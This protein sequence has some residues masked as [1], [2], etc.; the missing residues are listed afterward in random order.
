[1]ARLFSSWFA[2]VMAL[3]VGWMP[4][5]TA[6]VLP[7]GGLEVGDFEVTPVLPAKN[8]SKEKMDEVRAPATEP[9]AAVIIDCD[10]T[11]RPD[12]VV[13]KRLILE[14]E[15]SSGVTIDCDGATIDV[16]AGAVESDYII[17]IRSVKSGD[18]NSDGFP[19][20][21]RPQDITIKRCN[22]NGAV[23]IQGMDGSAN[24]TRF[25]DSS[26]QAG[27]VRRA[28]DAAP[29]RITL[30]HLTI[31]AVGRIPLYLSGGV[32]QVTVIDSEIQSKIG[33][34]I[35][36]EAE[37]AWN[38]IKNNVI[39][40]STTGE[41][42]LVAIDGSEYNVI[43]NNKFS[44]LSKGGIYLYRNCGEHG[45]VRHR[46]PSHNRII[47]NIFYYDKYDG[48]SPAVFLGSRSSNH[49]HYCDEDSDSEY[50]YGSSVDDHSFARYN[51]VMQNQIYKRSVSD[52][53]KEGDSS[54]RPNYIAHNETVMTEQSRLAGCYIPNGYKNFILHGETIDVF[55]SSTRVP[56]CI[57]STYTCND[58]D[59]EVSSTS[60][61]DM[62]QVTF[63]CQVSSNNNGCNRTASCPSG[64][65]IVG[66]VAACNLEYGSVTDSQLSTV[67]SGFMQVLRAS[68]N[69]SDGRCYLGGTSLRSGR[70]ELQGVLDYSTVTMG[71]DEHDNNGGDCHIRGTLYCR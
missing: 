36:L 71:C 2:L 67:P 39:H 24:G 28:R 49:S 33:V 26:R 12:D 4:P 6:A 66:A 18:T 43:M 45:T 16:E 62:D 63:D 60:T 65:R 32:T 14:G 50:K 61:C 8:C 51:V 31:T 44:A 27:H 30:D 52:M 10:L 54:N 7:I 38:V 53:I 47:N 17:E 40:R 56:M 34:A 19:S 41:R 69:V 68:D 3:V 48:M 55:K 21:S 15:D 1:M 29:R 35:Y 25:R 13:S 42:E 9:E 64:R 5:D 20:W 57:S 37:S 59:L 23:R 46:T 58:G 70:T 11:L 22:I